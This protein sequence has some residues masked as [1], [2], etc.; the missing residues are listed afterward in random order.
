MLISAC[1]FSLLSYAPVEKN[2][3]I[4]WEGEWYG[5]PNSHLFAVIIH[6]QEIQK[7]TGMI[8]TFPGG[9]VPRTLVSEYLIYLCNAKTVETNLSSTLK[10]PSEYD[11][12]HIRIL[13]QWGDD[14]FYASIQFEP[15]TRYGGTDTSVNRSETLDQFSLKIEKLLETAKE[16]ITLRLSTLIPKRKNSSLYLSLSLT[17]C[18]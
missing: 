7:P 9:G 18:T 2:S 4:N 12:Y 15:G 14:Y 3:T 10:P 5:K 17:I 6:Y 11:R 16:A 13:D 1:D 8:N